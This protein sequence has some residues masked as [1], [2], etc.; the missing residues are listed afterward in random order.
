MTA[1]K[2]R[3]RQGRSGDVPALQAIS[4]EAR[5][6]YRSLPELSHVANSTPVAAERFAIGD[7]VVAYV[8]GDGSPLGFALTRTLDGHLFLDNIS[9]ATHATGRRIGAELLGHVVRVASEA[10]LPRVIL[11]TFHRPPWN[12]PWFRRHGF[13]T[14]PAAN[15]GSGLRAILSQQAEHFDPTTR[16]VLWCL[17]R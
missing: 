15:Y 17:S 5:E 2:V 13:E 12:G 4:A 6:R 14:M 9:V 10:T 11:T 16:E 3:V 1:S 7:V 8:D